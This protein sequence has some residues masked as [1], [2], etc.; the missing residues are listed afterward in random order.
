MF[1]KGVNQEEAKMSEEKNVKEIPINF[2]ANIIGGVY[3]NNMVVA[4]TPE[5]FIMDFIMVVRPMAELRARVIMSPAH[6]KRTISALQDNLKKYE[7]RFG[8]IREEAEP[9]KPKP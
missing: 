3:C 8:K 9:E 1:V 4:H 5:E 7:E 6:M 2:P